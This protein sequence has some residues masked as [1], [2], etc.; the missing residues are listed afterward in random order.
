MPKKLIQS[1]LKELL[2]YDPET[3]IFTWLIS[4]GWSAKAGQV[5]GGICKI[6][7][8]R[9]I[10]IDGRSYPASRLAWFY[11]EGYWPENLVDHHDRIRH[12]DKWCNLRHVTPVCNAINCGI[13]KNNKSGITGVCWNKAMKKWESQ[14]QVLGKKIHLGHFK[15]KFDA[16]HVR[17]NAEV[18]HGFPNCNTTSSAYLYLN[19]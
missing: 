13:V 8:Y 7:G 2:Y 12:N 4:R 9:H 5:A 18:E 14:I 15:S 17:W 16:A 19:R 6:S 1:R 3:G 10:C 11:M